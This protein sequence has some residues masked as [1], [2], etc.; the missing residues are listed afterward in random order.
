MEQVRARHRKPERQR[1]PGPV[2]AGLKVISKPEPRILGWIFRCWPAVPPLALILPFLHQDRPAHFA[3]VIL[4]LDATLCLV[5]CMSVTPLLTVAKVKAHRYRMIYGVWMFVLGAAGLALAVLL[6]PE[7]AESMAG[8]SVAWT[9]TTLV[10]LLLPMTLTSNRVAQRWLGPEWKRWQRG[11]LWAVYVLVLGHLA[12]LQSYAVL[13]GFMMTTGP[14]IILRL[15]EVRK[16]IRTWRAG[17]YSTGGWWT[18]LAL[19]SASWLGGLV[20]LLTLTGTACAQAIH[21]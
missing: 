21:A 8:D 13:L 11:L 10:L 3:G 20:I 15:P 7:M 16:A 6:D 14:M 5:M 12:A 17:G 2:T 19:I 18:G 1:T 4:G 9:G